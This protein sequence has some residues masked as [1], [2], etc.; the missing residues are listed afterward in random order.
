MKASF[1]QTHEAFYKFFECSKLSCDSL[2]KKDT[3]IELDDTLNDSRMFKPINKL[4]IKYKILDE[5]P[6]S[7]KTFRILDSIHSLAKYSLSDYKGK[8]RCLGHF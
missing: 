4:F 3:L 7:Y 8:M 2:F 1:T 6:I 5:M